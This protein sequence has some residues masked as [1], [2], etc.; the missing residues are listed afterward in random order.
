MSYISSNLSYSVYPTLSTSHCHHCCSGPHIPNQGLINDL[1]LINNLS[2]R[3]SE[4][5][6]YTTA[7]SNTKKTLRLFTQNSINLWVL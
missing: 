2:S 6:E 3:Y 5:S 1:E 7:L 4:S